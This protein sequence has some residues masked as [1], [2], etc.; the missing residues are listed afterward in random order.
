M[1]L[2]INDK[3]TIK[4]LQ[5]DFSNEFPFLR[6]EF[7]NIPFAPGKSLPK[8]AIYA[9]DKALGGCRKIHNEGSL[10]IMPQD[11]VAKLEES[12]WQNFGLS[13]QVFRKSGRLWIETSLTDSWTLERQN[14]EGR[15]LS[16]YRYRDRDDEDPTDRDKWD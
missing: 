13:A 1:E 16:Q 6:V 11:T 3:R 9:T 7:F 14:D 2:F 5:D 12:L 10:T 4:E 15:E 8:S